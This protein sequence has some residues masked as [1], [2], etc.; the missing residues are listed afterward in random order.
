VE[1]DHVD[2][3]GGTD[4]GRQHDEEQDGNHPEHIDPTPLPYVCW[5]LGW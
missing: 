5:R 1:V 2:P 4:V 3:I